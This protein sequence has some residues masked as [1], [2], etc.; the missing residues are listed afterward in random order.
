MLC[1]YAQ[2][3]SLYAQHRELNP[4]MRSVTYAHRRGLSNAQHRTWKIKKWQIWTLKKYTCGYGCYTL[5]VVHHVDPPAVRRSERNHHPP[6]KFEDYISGI[7]VDV[8][9][10]TVTNISYS[11]YICSLH[12]MT[13]V[14]I[15]SKLL[16]LSMNLQAMNKQSKFQN[17]EKPWRKNLMLYKLIT[18][19][20]VL[21]FQKGKKPINYRWVYKIKYRVNGE[22]ERYKGRLVFKVYSQKAGIDYTE[23]FYNI[24]FPGIYLW[25]VV[26]YFC[27]FGLATTW[28]WECNDVTLD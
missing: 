18:L 15:W 24:I 8:C 10:H 5:H 23:T 25:V 12:W 13:R 19:G 9:L 26:I 17:W 21:I 22:V 2:C 16:V 3:K 7:V 28:H 27:P 1:T 11:N 20:L 4:R 14:N 6:I